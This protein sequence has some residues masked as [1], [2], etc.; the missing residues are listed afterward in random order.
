MTVKVYFETKTHAE[1]AAIFV[2]E[3]IYDACRPALGKLAREARMFVTE[4][5]EEEDL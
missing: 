4:S 1:L 5:V 3:D 2:S